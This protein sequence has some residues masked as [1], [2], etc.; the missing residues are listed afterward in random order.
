MG[1]Q[2]RNLLHIK[3][4]QAFKAWMRGKG[5]V[6]APKKGSYEVARFTNSSIKGDL[7]TVILFMKD[8][9]SEHVTVQGA[10]VG[11]VLDFINEDK[12]GG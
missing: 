8:G 9:A 12:G 7:K 1:D 3:Q 6:L 5:Y 2:R 10:A 11:L 4:I